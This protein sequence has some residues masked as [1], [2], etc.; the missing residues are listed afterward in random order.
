MRNNLDNQI[1]K[2][3]IYN[4]DLEQNIDNEIE[5]DISLFYVD[6][7]ILNRIELPEKLAKEVRSTC[8]SINKQRKRRIRDNILDIIIVLSVVVPI[9]G[10]I[11]P[12]LFSKYPNVYPVFKSI[13]EIFQKEKIIS[14][15]GI[16]TNKEVI[17]G[18]GSSSQETVYIKDED[19]KVP[20][21][22]Y[23]SVKLIHSMANSI[24]H[25]E[26]KWEC[27]EITPNTISKALEGV[28]FIKDDYDRMHLR[29]SLTKWSKGNFN[30][31]VDV[32]NYVWEM[33]D[34]TVGKAYTADDNEIKKILNTYFSNN[35]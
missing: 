3:D 7:N 35:E 22:H 23:E 25:A 5:K 26:Y 20:T 28:E 2:L 11:Q 6:S 4:M 27:T 8:K 17:E 1:S 12:K 32:H 14:I 33:L 29:N 31:A 13:N 16:T 34:G 10:I 24:I 18:E 19:V 30:N 9:I 15:L 21:N